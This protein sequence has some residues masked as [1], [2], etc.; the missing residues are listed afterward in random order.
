MFYLF[1]FVDEDLEKLK[2]KDPLKLEQFYKEYK[3]KVFNFLLIKTSG[4]QE[5]VEEVFSDTFHSAILNISKLQN[6]KNIQGWIIQIASRRLSDYFRKMYREKK[7]LEKIKTA[8]HEEKNPVEDTIEKKQEAL[9]VDMAMNNLKDTYKEVI[10]LKYIEK[11]S[12]NEI[13]EKLGKTVSSINNLLLR[14]RVELRNEFKKVVGE[15]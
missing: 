10:Q 13:S 7:Y 3:D 15:F 4:N 8:H 2:N 1:I 6:V 11:K 12:L 14:A 5:I 9:M